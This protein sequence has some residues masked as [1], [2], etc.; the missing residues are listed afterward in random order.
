MKG[1][2]IF[3]LAVVLILIGAFG[4][5][6]VTMSG[7]FTSISAAIEGVHVSIAPLIIIGIVF[8]VILILGIYLRRK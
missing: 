6:A 4:L 5:A 3:L 1:F 8:F 2:L 7:F